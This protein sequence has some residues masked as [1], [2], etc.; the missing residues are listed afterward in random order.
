MADHVNQKAGQEGQNNIAAFLQGL[1]DDQLGELRKAA[2][3]EMKRRGIVSPRK[4]GEGGKQKRAGGGGK[5]KRAS[6]GAA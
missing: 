2:G 1:P 3:K 4:Q 6:E 5:R